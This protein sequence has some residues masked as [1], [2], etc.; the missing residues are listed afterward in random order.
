MPLRLTSLSVLI[1]AALPFVLAAQQTS[2]DEPTCEQVYKN[3]QVFKGVPAKDLI[4]SMEFMAASLKVKCS[5]CHEKDDFAAETQGKET[6]RHMV[7]LQRDINTKFFNGRLSVTCMSCHNGREH[8]SSTPVPA[9]ATMRHQRVQDPVKPEELFKKHMTA[10]GDTNG[11]VT[12]AGTMTTPAEDG[13]K[14]ESSPV[15]LIQ[16]PEG[17]FRLTS[18]VYT[19]G[20]D[21]KQVWKDSYPLQ[22]EPAAIFSRM[23]RSWRGAHTF[24]GLERIT[25][26]G[27]EKLGKTSTLV[28]RGVRTSTGATEEMYFD[29]KSGM[30]VRFVNMTRSTL[31]SVV[32]VY[33]YSNFKSV[34]GVKVPMKVTYT[35]AGDETW[36]IDYKTAAVSDKVDDKIFSPGQR[37]Q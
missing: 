20:S 9:G 17:K 23:G 11:F 32:S 1:V 24:D 15:E 27:R 21:G 8:P 28:V 25:V 22:D 29:E 31:G 18:K 30:L 13:G 7:L 19:F 12:L 3:I 5:F 34:K 10:V 33:D 26:S 14:P 16:G 2:T 37:A 36:S 6:G 4:P 35:F